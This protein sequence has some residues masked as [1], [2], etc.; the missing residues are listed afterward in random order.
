MKDR[1]KKV[2][3][4]GIAL[5]LALSM[6]ACGKKDT[7]PASSNAVATTAPTPTAEPSPQEQIIGKWSFERVTDQS[8]N[9]VDLGEVQVEGGAQK[10]LGSVLKQGATVEFTEEG[11][12][13]FSILSADYTFT[14]KDT[15]KVSSDLVDTEISIPAAVSNDTLELNIS[16]YTATFERVN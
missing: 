9:E 3:T 5:A 7:V 1:S 11:K 2:L 8:G 15:I 13:K 12:I 10:L 6:S 4:I 14:D 16:G